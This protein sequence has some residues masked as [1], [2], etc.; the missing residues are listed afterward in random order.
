MTAL[1]GLLFFIGWCALVVFFG[2]WIW[3][4]VRWHGYNKEERRSLM[5]S[6]VLGYLWPVVVLRS[7]TWVRPLEQRVAFVA[8]SSGTFF[9]V[10]FGVG[11]LASVLIGVTA[12]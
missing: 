9:V 3:L 7:S 12:P 5:N 6:V 1:I 10:L 2:T 4:S 11:S 8:R